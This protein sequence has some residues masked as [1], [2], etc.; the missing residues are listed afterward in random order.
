MCLGYVRLKKQILLFRLLNRIQPLQILQIRE[1]L[2][3][4]DI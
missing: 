2:V 3:N 4:L 1:F